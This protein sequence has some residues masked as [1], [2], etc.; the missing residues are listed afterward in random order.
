VAATAHNRAVRG[1]RVQSKTD[2]IFAALVCVY[3]GNETKWDK[4]EIVCAGHPCHL[5]IGAKAQ[6]GP[7]GLRVRPMVD[8]QC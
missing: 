8:L 5:A 7:R 2:G 6:F 4:L 3:K 1:T